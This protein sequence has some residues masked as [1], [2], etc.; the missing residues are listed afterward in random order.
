MGAF[1]PS[2]FIYL[3]ICKAQWGWTYSRSSTSRVCPPSVHAPIS[4]RLGGSAIGPSVICH[5]LL[6]QLWLRASGACACELSKNLFEFTPALEILLEFLFLWD[7]CLRVYCRRER[8]FG[9]SRAEPTSESCA[10]YRKQKIQQP[11]KRHKGH[12]LRRARTQFHS[13][14]P[15]RDR[16][17]FGRFQCCTKP[18]RLD[19]PSR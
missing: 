5:F 17:N 1:R 14:Q 3:F 2:P 18:I 7:I 16:M 19:Q 12:N 9:T 6:V 8:A 13:D 15:A 11:G 4:F 10:Q